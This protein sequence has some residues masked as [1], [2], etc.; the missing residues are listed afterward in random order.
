MSTLTVPKHVTVCEVGPRDGL[1]NEKSQIDAATKLEL[2]ARLGDAGAPVIEATSFVHPKWIPQLAD[3]EQVAR[4]LERDNGVR[5]TALVP[6]EAGLRRALELE[7]KEIGV[8]A[9]VTETFSQKNLNRSV[10]ESFEMIAP[11][12]RDAKAAGMRI[13]G[14]LS[15]VWGDPWEGPTEP[16]QVRSAAEQMWALEIDELSLGDTIGV[17]T[18]TR[19]QAVLDE[20]TPFVPLEQLVVHFHDTYGQALANVL[21]ALQSGVTIVD[22][23]VGGLGGCPYAKSAT[24]NLATEDLVYMLD[25]MGVETGLSLDSLIAT[26]WWV[27]DQLGREPASRVTRA[28]GRPQT[29][30]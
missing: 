19:V 27:C 9:S 4:G 17:A 14:T 11:V 20:L 21:A 25:G 26:A 6:N 15:M 30:A 29:D 12:V 7:M 24:G 23:S 2:I 8:F 18:P 22:S 28:A 3:A 13:R 16:A 10:A 1:Q 5:Y